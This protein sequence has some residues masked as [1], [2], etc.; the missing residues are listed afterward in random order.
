MSPQPW[1]LRGLSSWSPKVPHVW[2]VIQE[3]H[4]IMSY[5]CCLSTLG[6]CVQGPGKK[7]VTVLPG[8]TEHQEEVGLLLHNW[9][10]EEHV[11]NADDPLGSLN[12]LPNC[13]CKKSGTVTTAGAGHVDQGMRVWVMPLIRHCGQQSW[14]LKMR[15]IR[16]DSEGGG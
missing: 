6:S 16:M 1:A 11:W 13:D 2:Q 3:S 10:R 15:A 12:L 9:G 4:W 8:V 7:S 14:K 5:G